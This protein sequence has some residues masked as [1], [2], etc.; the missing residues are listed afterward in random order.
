MDGK[1][2]L[3]ITPPYHCGVVEVAGRW[4]PLTFAYLAG[5]ARNAGFEPIIY[6]AMTKRD[7]F[8]EIEKKI[9]DVAP[10]YV[11]TSAITSTAL[12]AVEVLRVAKEVNPDIVTVIGGVHPSF[13]YKEVLQGGFVDYV[14]RGEGEITLAELL[15]TLAKQKSPSS[16]KGVAYKQGH[17]VIATRPRP[18]IEDLDS[19]TPAWDLIEWQDY[20]YFVIPK[21]RLGSVSTSRG[22]SHACTFCSQQ[23]F[24][25]QTWR[26][27]KPESVVCEIEHLYNRY[28]VNVFLFPDEHPTHDRARWESILDHLITK[29]LDIYILMETRAEDIIRDRDILHKYRKSGIIHIYIGVEATDQE[30]LDLIK[31]DD[32]VETGIEAIRLIHEHGM[33][34]E[35]SFIL[36]FPHET[37]ESINKTLQLANIYNPDFAHFLA[38]APWPYA[39]IYEEMKPYIVDK[40][41]RKYNLIE[42]VIKPE[43]MSIKEI[44]KA[45]IECYQGFYMR[46]LKEIVMMQDPFKKRYLLHSMKLIMNSSFIVDKLGNLSAIPQKVKALVGQLDDQYFAESSD[47]EY[48]SLAKDSVII[49][50]APEEVFAF[51]SN[52]QNWPEFINGLIEVK[53]TDPNKIEAGALFEWQYRF[54]GLNFN[55]SGM[56]ADYIDNK[57]IALKMHSMIP[58]VEIIN[59]E[60]TSKGTSLTVEVGYKGSSKVVS[61]LFGLIKKTLNFSETREVLNRIRSLCEGSKKQDKSGNQNVNIL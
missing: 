11:L 43:K 36:G 40:D 60:E 58:I 39:D 61:F 38:L 25:H 48:V 9:I 20:R 33:V 57:K 35:T 55:G 21:S 23:K 2:L 28:G 10:D 22:C 12:D 47:D 24:W 27:R 8:K 7:G 49:D 6:D 29:D 26:G 54:M 41:Y 59:L 19:L 18:L 45:I 34:T 50:S 5:Q 53:E 44:D 46:K 42:P 13:L 15:A 51:V 3:F 4:L 1:K 31:K 16:V 56:I 14:V 52:P 17:R 30:T 37:K 32:K